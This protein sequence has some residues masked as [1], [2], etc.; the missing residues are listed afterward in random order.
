MTAA[1]IDFTTTVSGASGSSTA[2][3]STSYGNLSTSAAA[4]LVIP[5]TG[6]VVLT[7]SARVYNTTTSDQ[8]AFIGFTM[9]GAN[10]QAA[11]DTTAVSSKIVGGNADISISRE[12]LLTGLTP[13]STTFTLQRRTTGGSLVI[14]YADL[15][16]KAA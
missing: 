10:T 16:V 12:R 4:T 14:G 15:V 1:K 2:N 5:S 13:G 8:T 6:R 7:I 9:S 11:S 3:A